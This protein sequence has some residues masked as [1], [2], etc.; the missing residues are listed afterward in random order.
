MEGGGGVVCGVVWCGEGEERG[1][2]GEGRGEDRRGVEGRGGE[3]RGGE[4][5][6]GGWKGQLS[7]C[8]SSV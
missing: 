5:K 3:G 8:M 2:T 4:G 7:R 1:G 6:E